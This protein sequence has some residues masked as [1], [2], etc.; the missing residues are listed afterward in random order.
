VY[1][2]SPL[3]REALLAAAGAASLAALLVWL[4]PPGNDLAAHVY[5]RAVFLDDGYEL[6]NNFWYGGR[7]SFVT[8]SVIY[9]PLAA[10]LG[11]QPLAV[12]SIATA[13]L[14][15]AVVV[16]RQWGP[17]ARWSSRSFAVVWAGLIISAAFPFAL[18]FAFGL[19]A[20]WALQAEKRWQFGVLAVLT[21][22]ASPLAF[23]LLSIVLAG[24]ALDLRARGRRLLAPALIIV[25]I[26]AAQVLLTRAFADGGRYPFPNWQLAAVVTF[27]VLGV[28]LTWRVERAQLL[29]WFFPALLIVCLFSYF[30]PSP[31]GENV[32]RIR[33]VALPIAVLIF[34]IR[35]WRPMPVAAFALLLAA[36]WNLSPHAWSFERG[37]GEQPAA[38]ASY[39]QPAID[40]LNE[41]LTPSYRVE[42]VDTAG[43][44]AAVHLPAVGIPLVRGWFRQ[45]DFPQNEVLY[46][47]LN[48]K[49]YLAWLRNLGVK[50]VVLSDTPTDYSAKHEATLVAGGH[51]GLRPVAGSDRLTVF[52]VPDARPIVTGPAPAEVVDVGKGHILVRLERPGRYRVAVRYSP[53]WRSD[54]GCVAKGSDGMLVFAARRA[55]LVR[56]EFRVGAKRALAAV[57]GAAGPTCVDRAQAQAR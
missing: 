11:I 25:G 26:G 55:G 39:W 1:R 13:A 38:Q 36:A 3:V 41:N 20:L 10:L 30:V 33:L 2:T 7:Y 22:L 53:Y 54:S 5:Q 45:D 21:L 12:A 48:R 47:N 56:L 14:A 18:G 50:Y 8:Y 57:V 40:Y 42:V 28:A 27:C 52:A 46:E 23:L 24:V 34:S 9:Y 49:T 17:L 44:W 15:F 4:G 35:G 31:L 51:S 16:G 6:W 32:A 37:R 19:L 29:R 43:H